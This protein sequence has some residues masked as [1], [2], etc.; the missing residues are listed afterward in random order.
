MSKSY[1]DK[2]AWISVLLGQNFIFFIMA[3]FW[4]SSIFFSLSLYNFL[5]IKFMHQVG[6][7]SLPFYVANNNAYFLEKSL[8]H[9]LNLFWCFVADFLPSNRSLRKTL[10]T[11][12]GPWLTVVPMQ[13]WRTN[14]KIFG[15][16][17]TW[18]MAASSSAIFFW[19]SSIA[20]SIGVK[21]IWNSPLK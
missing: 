16:G 17:G 20:T 13:P 4:A 11:S 10:A 9:S 21:T 6:E 15:L 3:Y 19:T 14:C 18:F 2:I 8:K 5:F 7:N 12:I 1:V